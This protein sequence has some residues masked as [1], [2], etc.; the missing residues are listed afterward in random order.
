LQLQ[1]GPGT[2]GV[3]ITSR[4]NIWSQGSELGFD[5]TG[6]SADDIVAVAV[7]LDAR[8]IW[9]KLVA[10]PD[11]DPDFC[12][13]NGDPANDPATG[14]GGLDISGVAGALLPVAAFGGFQ[15]DIPGNA[16]TANFCGP[17]TG[18]LPTGFTE[19]CPPAPPVTVR[20][21]RLLVPHYLALIG[22][23][24]AGLIVTEGIEIPVGWIPTLACEPLTTGAIQSYWDAGPRYAA[25]AEYSEDFYPFV[26][27]Q[28]PAVY[29]QPLGPLGYFQLT[30]AGAS[31]GA[32]SSG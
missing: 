29:W 19:W 20:Q 32:K 24:E 22:Y 16:I 6:A 8:L 30:G 1:Y 7:D 17:F 4:G 13:W 31:L 5:N 12:F 2:D 28:R 21:Y 10:G 18:T 27:I 23:A 25:G 11:F 26:P 14:V 9:F 3:I 15:P